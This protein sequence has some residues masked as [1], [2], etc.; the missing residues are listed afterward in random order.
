MSNAPNWKDTVAALPPSDIALTERL[1]NARIERARLTEERERRELAA[2]LLEEVEAEERALRDEQAIEK[3]VAEH[4]PIGVK[5]AVMH[6]PLGVIIIKKPNHV[7][8]R[9]FQDLGKHDVVEC[10]KLI[11]PCLV[12][13]DKTEFDRY[14]TELP[15]TI[16][17][18]ANLACGLCGVKQGEAAGK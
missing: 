7:L 8:F 3:A 10:E 14:A 1:Q 11:R 18:L 5:L 13:P 12:H 6:T 15:G 9:R 16:I 2:S 17:P 4:G